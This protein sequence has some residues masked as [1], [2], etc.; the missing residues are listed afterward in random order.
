MRGEYEEDDD[1]DESW[2]G[3]REDG[4]ET[5]ACGKANDGTRTEPEGESEGLI[6]EEEVGNRH[7][8]FGCDAI[9]TWIGRPR[10]DRDMNEEK[11]RE[12]GEPSTPIRRTSTITGRR[13]TEKTTGGGGKLEAGADEVTG[14]G[15]RYEATGERGQDGKPESEGGYGDEG[16]RGRRGRHE[17]EHAL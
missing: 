2:H 14:A 13:K 1:D 12:G 4:W 7:V 11:G 3:A 9:R 16:R 8:R 15:I 6:G 10:W 5:T 17:M